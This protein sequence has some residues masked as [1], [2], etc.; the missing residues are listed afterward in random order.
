ML[1]F[2]NDQLRL[3]DGKVYTYLCPAEKPDHCYLLDTADRN[4]WPTRVSTSF[5][6]EAVLVRQPDAPV[7]QHQ[8]ARSHAKQAQMTQRWRVI[9]PLVAN[10]KIFE[11]AVRWRLIE[12]RAKEVGCSPATVMGYLRRYWSY[13]QTQEAL[14]YIAPRGPERRRRRGGRQPTYHNRYD[15]GPEDFV[16]FRWA[17]EQVFLKNQYSTMQAAYEDLLHRKY[18]RQDEEDRIVVFPPGERPSKA[19]FVAY[20]KENYSDEYRARKRHGDKDYDSNVRGSFGTSRSK[21]VGAGHVYEMDATIVDVM[22]VS[23]LDRSLII[24]RPTLFY[25]V[26]AFSRLIVGWYLGLESPSWQAALYAIFSISDDKEKVCT[27]LGI[28]YRPDQWPA[29]EILPKE[30]HADR[31][32]AMHTDAEQLAAGLRVA[33]TNIPGLRGDMKGLVE[34]KFSMTHKAMADLAPGYSPGR[35]RNTRRKSD[36]SKTSALT[37]HELERIVVRSILKHNRTPLANPQYTPQEFRARMVPSPINLWTFDIENQTGRL[38]R[39]SANTLRA[40]LLPQE[41]ASVTRNGFRIGDCFY[42]ATEPALNSL[43]TQGRQIIATLPCHIHRNQVD[44]IHIWFGDELYPAVLTAR[45][46]LYAGL[47]HMEAGSVAEEL[48]RRSHDDDQ[49]RLNNKVNFR[50]EVRDISDKAR[51]ATSAVA[52]GLSVSSRRKEIVQNRERERELERTTVAEH[53]APSQ[54]EN[55]GILPPA[56]PQSS[57]S[58]NRLTAVVRALRNAP[59]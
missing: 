19:Q 18:S 35:N 30:I 14:I 8:R 17:A 13:G 24:G 42:Q 23:Q 40:T 48:K 20:L 9:Q 56:S 44:T 31:G 28:R 25:L 7:R 4:C 2:A 39:V 12:E 36:G 21:A 34:E 51:S 1:P 10:P 50:S 5:L 54:S 52:K 15:C 59:Q 32:E 22:L 37:L 29:H 16:H 33:V 26:C 6:A 11:Y 55:S 49:I 47:S 53:L 27:R 41:W 43:C 38:S 57:S 46:E 45:S 58:K 3:P